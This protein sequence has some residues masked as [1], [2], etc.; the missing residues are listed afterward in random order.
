MPTSTK[1]AFFEDNK[2]FFLICSG[3]GRQMLLILSTL[4]ERELL[5]SRFGYMVTYGERN[6]QRSLM[7]A[8]GKI[9]VPAVIPASRSNPRYK[10]LKRMG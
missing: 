9:S 5:G 1:F 6:V 2:W 8:L 7:W 10:G 4:A 3:I